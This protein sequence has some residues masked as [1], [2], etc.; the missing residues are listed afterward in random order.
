M[1]ESGS[2]SQY[3]YSRSLFVHHLRTR[4][5]Y[6]IAS[7]CAMIGGDDCA[8][9]GSA[10]A[11][12]AFVTPKGRAVALVFRAGVASVTAFNTLG[13][14]RVL[15]SGPAAAIAAMSLTLTDN[16]ASWVNAG[17]PRTASIAP[18]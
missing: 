18:G 9:T 4:R 11:P 12:A 6:T 5:S 8:S 17:V 16:V 14:A 7:T 3:A 2:S 13:T 1:I 10:T 15:D